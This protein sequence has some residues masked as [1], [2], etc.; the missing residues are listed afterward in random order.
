M[1]YWQGYLL[2]T[3]MHRIIFLI[4]TGFLSV[5]LA[6]QDGRNFVEVE[7]KTLDKEEFE[8]PDDLNAGTVN[9]VMLAISKDQDNGT[10]QGDLLVEWY[11]SLN[12]AGL[13]NDEVKAWHF[14][15]MKVPFFVKGIIRNGMAES[16]E[17][18]LPLNQAGPI[19]LKD[20]DGFAEQAGIVIDELPTIVLV[21]PDG[22]LHETFKGGPTK[23]RLAAV[24]AAVAAYTDCEAD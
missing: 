20:A 22:E 19:Y 6:A 13:L 10:L 11:S 23:E 2:G 18:K 21:T 15:V 4:L 3:Q 9:I 8:F 17:G 5:S 12:A 16:Y 1:F 24:S 14:S 7:M